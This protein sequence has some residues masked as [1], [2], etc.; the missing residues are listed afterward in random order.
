MEIQFPVI[1]HGTIW[2]RLLLAAV[3][4][5]VAGCDRQGLDV[6]QQRKQTPVVS[7]ANAEPL[8]PEVDIRVLLLQADRVKLTCPGSYTIWKVAG[9]KKLADLPGQSETTLTFAHGSWQLTDRQGTALFSAP[10]GA[11]DILEI[12]PG[13]NSLIA[14]G[15]EKTMTYRGRVRCILQGDSRIAV[16]NVLPIES[17]LDGVVGAEMWSH[18]QMEALCCQSIASRTYA[19]YQIHRRQG[20]GH[21]DLRSTQNSQVYRGLTGENQRVAQAVRQTRSMVLACGPAGKEKIFPAYFSAICGG[22]TEDAQVVF[23]QDLEPLKGRKCPYCEKSAPDDYYRWP[24]LELSK[25]LV[26]RKLL[27]RYSSLKDLK[28][29]VDIEVV[30]KSEYGRVEKLSLT[31]SQGL[32]RTIAAEPFRLAIT[33]A[34]KPLRS[35]WYR[36]KDG[37]SVWK[38]QNGRGFGHGVGMCQYGCEQMARQGSNCRT[39]LQ[40]YYPQAIL[41]RAYSGYGAN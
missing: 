8:G 7:P 23:K 34:E 26:S 27:E 10:A 40:H 41:V 21:W 35:S 13:P 39:I 9:D 20:R 22:H 31:G 6:E 30:Q 28:A 2:S 38:F 12:R 11:G 33:S 17:Y 37:R 15:T 18:W 14:V 3:L 24:E 25:E 29:I 16:V 5:A 36:L 19:L 32:K 4:A 1:I